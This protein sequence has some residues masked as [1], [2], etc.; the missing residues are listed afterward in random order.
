ME[1]LARA[2]GV[3]TGTIEVFVR[4]GAHSFVSK[5]SSL[6]DLVDEVEKLLK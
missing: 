6:T 4:R 2:A 5:S 1:E 3:Q